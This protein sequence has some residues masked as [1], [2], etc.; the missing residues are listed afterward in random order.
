M[1]ATFLP[2][3]GSSGTDWISLEL[4]L[5]AMLMKKPEQQREKPVW[6][7]EL[8]AAAEER[9]RILLA[10]DTCSHVSQAGIGPNEFLRRRGIRLPDYYGTGLTDNFVESIMC[11]GCIQDNL[12]DTYNNWWKSPPHRTHVWGETGFFRAQ[13]YIGL[14]FWKTAERSVWTFLSLER[15]V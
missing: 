6:D 7:P 5:F 10:E 2:I 14:G 8:R 9:C 11:C 15:S 1:P 3:I 13:E 12:Q 4:N